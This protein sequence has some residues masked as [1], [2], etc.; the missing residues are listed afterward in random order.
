[1]S[2]LYRKT[3]GKLHNHAKIF[4]NATVIDNLSWLARTIPSSIGIRFVDAGQWDDGAADLV[5]WTDASGKYGLSFVFA[6]NGFVYQ[7]R[8][9]EPGSPSIDIFFLELLAILS[10]IHHVAN[11][12][13]PPH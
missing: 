7:H 8:S 10:G 13:H 12:A 9:P 5:M 2:E 4:L 6:G 3:A 11:F 1:L